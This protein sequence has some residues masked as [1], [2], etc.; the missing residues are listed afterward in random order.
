LYPLK[1]VF[2]PHALK[3]MEER[4][5]PEEGACSTLEEPN[6]EYPSNLEGTVVERVFSSGRLATKV[7]FD[8]AHEQPQRSEYHDVGVEVWLL[9]RASHV[10][11]GSWW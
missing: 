10:H 6:L 3:R 1:I 11:L 2:L 8:A 4:R 9:Y 5:I 7:V